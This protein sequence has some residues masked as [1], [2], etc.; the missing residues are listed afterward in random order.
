M[1]KTFSIA[2][3]YNVKPS[4]HTMTCTFSSVIYCV[5]AANA[6]QPT[7]TGKSEVALEAALAVDNGQRAGGG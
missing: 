3:Y 7:W 5:L 6:R 4:F 1:Q 2:K